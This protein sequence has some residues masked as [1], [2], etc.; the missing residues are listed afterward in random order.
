MID[1]PVFGLILLAAALHASWN[2]FLKGSSDTLLSTTLVMGGAA[3]IA[4]L[5]LPFLPVPARASWPYLAVSALLQ[6]GYLA[7]L[8]RIYRVVDMSLAYPLMRGCAPLAVALVSRLWL[9]EVLPGLAWIGVVSIS[10]GILAMAAGA[11]GTLGPAGQAAVLTN[12][13]LI[14]AYTLIDGVGAR[15]SGTP[16]AYTLWLSLLT[17]AALVAWAI[18]S[19]GGALISYARRNWLIG[20][21]GG[22][23][24]IV[25]YTI[26]LWAM[27]M[28]PIA[29]VAALRE[30][31]ILFATAIAALVLRE[32]VSRVRVAAAC[33]IA[34][35]A[36]LLRLA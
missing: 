36:M 1:L 16:A 27:T 20:L 7:L 18:T 19:R 30:T 3:L 5:A 2:A 10:L 11:R 13:A 31:S 33:I 24:T 12:A 15:L 22:L 32:P 29:L 25:S 4:V 17:G 14:A 9:G 8:V 23:G 34:A 26:A 35:G 21:I 6:A 28:A